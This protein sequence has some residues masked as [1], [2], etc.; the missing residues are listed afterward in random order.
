[1]ETPSDF[2]DRTWSASLIQTKMVPP[3]LPFGC[4]RRHALLDRL[5][6]QQTHGITVVTA[7]AG[8]G[9]TTLLAGCSEVLSRQEYPVA[10]L[11][12][13]GE[14]NQEQ[15]F[16]AYLVAAFCRVSKDIGRPA[17]QLLNSDARTSIKTIISVLLNGI[18][19]FGRRVFLVL[20]DVDRLTSAPVI[21]VVSRLLRYAPEN[22]HVLLGARGEPGMK[23]GQL[24]APEK[25]TR[26]SANDL[27]FSIDDAEKFF[28]ET[29]ALSLDRANVELLNGVTEGWVAGLQLAALALRQTSDPAQVVGR[30]TVTRSGIDRYLD[31]AVLTQLPPAMLEFLLSTSILERLSPA[32]CDAVMAVEGGSGEK[33]EWLEQHNVFIRPLDERREWYR[34]H[35]LLSDALRRRLLAHMPQQVPVLHQRAFRWFAEKRLWSEAVRHALAAGEFEQAAQLVENGAMEMLERG[36]SRTLLEW[37]AKLPPDVVLTRRLRLAKAWALAFS[38][39]TTHAIK[40]IRVVTDEI[41]RMRRESAC[42][43]DEVALAEVNAISGIIASASDQSEHAFEFGHAVATSSAIAAPW[44]NSC[45]QFAQFFGLLHRGEFDQIRRIWGGAQDRPEQGRGSIYTDLFRNTMYGLAAQMHG[46]LAEAGRVLEETLVRAENAFGYASSCAVIAAGCLVS[47]VYEYNQLPRARKLIANRTTIAL[48]VSPL[49]TLLRHVL[50]E[51]RLLQRNG[52]VGSALAVLEDGRQVAITRQ[53]LRLKMACDAETVRLLL[54]SGDVT[55]ARQI[56][57]KLRASMPVVLD[58]QAGAATETWTHYCFLQARV[59]IAENDAEKAVAFLVRLLDALAARGWRYHEAIA[60]LLL[61]LAYEQ[62]GASGS[63][64]GALDRALR[65]GEAVGMVNSFIDE[66]QGVRALLQRFRWNAG[67]DSTVDATYVDKLIHAFDN[68]DAPSSTSPRPVRNLKMS[69]EALSA[70][71]FEVLRCVAHGQSNKEVGRSLKL[72]PET[73]KWHMKNIFEKLDVTSR[74]EAVQSVFGFG[75]REG[76]DAM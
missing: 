32:V 33:L 41:Y 63:A 28:E 72:A 12:L 38:L 20:D 46:E 47:I 57:N 66:G 15:Q 4:V 56:A 45:A 58:E 39:Q 55:R 19:A 74:I 40:E 36:E 49:G 42:S 69:S 26:I 22:M 9:K 1:M 62:G 65:L 21:A 31:D 76:S 52:Q 35:A 17:Q 61:S 29:C 37:V 34:L 43:I 71:E 54:H 64:L 16:G 50:T 25:L 8:F 68:V 6:E 24:R 23:L 10:W 11:S 27:R 53:W 18:A 30:F 67:G 5:S 73:V 7:P 14:D 48:E 51:A 70:R 75:V 13:D 60:S 2:A 3:L 44:V 59:L